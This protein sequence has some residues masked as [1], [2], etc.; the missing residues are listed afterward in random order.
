MSMNLIEQEDIVFDEEPHIY[1]FMGKR[2]LSVTQVIRNAG[3]GEDFGHVTHE[4]MDH[5]RHRGRLVH[6]ACQFV[7]EGT[8]DMESVHE[9]LRGY[10]ESYIL[11]R[12]ECKI[13]P[14]AI[15]KKMLAPE[16]GLAGTPDL[17]CWM[18]GRRVVIDRKTSQV[19]NKSMGLQTAGYSFLWAET[20]GSFIYERFGLR[21]QS[22]GRYKLFQHED[23]DDHLA[24][25]QA[26][27]TPELA[28]ERWGR[29]YGTN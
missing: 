17:I 25:M 1:T 24:F 20:Q 4:I 27:N 23:P 10:V 13:Q 22:G 9:S 12:K 16:I 15:E 3:L 26:L 29:K 2:H 8:L 18:S 6:M 21:L 11:F 14:I 28:Q 7:D 5:A 19:M